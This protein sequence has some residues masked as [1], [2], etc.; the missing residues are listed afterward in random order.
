MDGL[1]YASNTTYDSTSAE[2]MVKAITS[3]QFSGV[4]NIYMNVG[5]TFPS[6]SDA[7]ANALMTFMDNG[8]NVMVCG[9][10]IAW[11]IMSGSGYGTSVTQNLFTNYF[12]ASYVSD[13]STANNLINADVS[14]VIFGDLGSSA[15]IDTY[16]GN[17]YPDQISPVNGASSIFQY[18]NSASKISGV[19]YTN[20][21]YKLVYIGIGM[22]QV[23]DVA[24]RKSIIKRAHDWFYGIVNSVNE[25]NPLF[26]NVDI[27]P[28]PANNVL[29]VKNVSGFK[30]LEILNVLGETVVYQNIT[31]NT[32]QVDVQ[33][34]PAGTYF[35]KLSN[36]QSFFTSK[37]IKQ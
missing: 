5:W 23:S 18:N 15:V 34:L 16:N 4:N 31:A 35:V 24:V 1:A 12:H 33:K 28:V 20:G 22:E 25:N 30:T 2:V 36:G 37:I 29:T 8:G 26:T 19:R 14:D 9:Q 7:D 21:T 27:Y 11:D 10:D 13:G 6:F 17:M 3:G 32:M